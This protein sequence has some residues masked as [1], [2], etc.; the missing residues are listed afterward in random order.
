MIGDFDKGRRILFFVVAHV[1]EHL[2][3]LIELGLPIV[4]RGV[5]RQISISADDV[6]QGDSLQLGQLLGGTHLDDAAGDDVMDTFDDPDLHHVGHPFS[7]TPS[8]LLRSG[9]WST[10]PGP[11]ASSIRMR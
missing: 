3:R 8:S 2:A 6:D 10:L 11:P 7:S 5:R 1:V 4:R 9:M